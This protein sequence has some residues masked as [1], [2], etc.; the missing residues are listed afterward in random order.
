MEQLSP[1]KQLI[2]SMPVPLDFTVLFN[3][4]RAYCSL[5]YDRRTVVEHSCI[6]QCCEKLKV[7]M[8]NTDEV[9]PYFLDNIYKCGR[10]EYYDRTLRDINVNK[11]L[12]IYSKALFDNYPKLQYL[13]GLTSEALAYY[14]NWHMAVRC[15]LAF[16]NLLIMTITDGRKG[17]FYDWQ[18]EEAYKLLQAT[19]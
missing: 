5:D 6:K 13:T 9:T 4:F 7:V 14:Q 11:A 8:P 16:S 2:D 3:N 12:K 19:H 17:Y 10:I 15:L 18:L 1:V